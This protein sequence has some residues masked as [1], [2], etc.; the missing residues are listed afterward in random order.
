MNL[1]R[2]LEA[3]FRTSLRERNQWWVRWPQPY[4]PETILVQIMYGTS[5]YRG[6]SMPYTKVENHLM[7]F[8][9]T[10]TI[11]QLYDPSVDQEYPPGIGPG[12][13]I[14][15]PLAGQYTLLRH[16]CSALPDALEGE[17][18]GLR[19]RFAINGRE[20]LTVASGPDAGKTMT[21]YDINR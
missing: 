10:P 7:Y 1:G 13:F 19:Q 20:I 12:K 21:A 11:T 16:E 9:V 6:T 4:Q 15:G 5:E 18:R 14:N 3:K 2:N 8:P 17:F